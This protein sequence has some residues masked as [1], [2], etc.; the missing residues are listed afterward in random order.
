MCINFDIVID[1]EDYS[2]D[3]N[4]GLETLKGASEATRQIATTLLTGQVP[5]KLTSTNKIRTKLRKTFKGSFGQEYSLEIECSALKKTYEDIGENVFSEL[6][7]YFINEAL[8]KESNKLSNKANNMI[9]DLGEEC[10]DELIEQLRKSSLERLH[11]ISKNFKKNVKLRYRESDHKQA[12]LA[13]INKDSYL[14]LVPVINRG[15]V[16]IVASITR[17]NINT[18]NGRLLIPGQ[19]ET[20][21]FGF[22]SS[23]KDVKQAAKKK[24]SE[25][26]DSNNGIHSDKWKTLRLIAHTLRTKDGRIIKYLIEGILGD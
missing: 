2:V 26:L 13:D 7:G 10:H 18:G 16:D 20:V 19:N 6:V 14:S 1:S 25:N 3:M 11:T 4:S 22:P 17:L 24:F 21:A 23:Y 9:S 8:Y 5:K 15:K 12:T